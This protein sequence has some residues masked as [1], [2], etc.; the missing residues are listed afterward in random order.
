LEKKKV[1]SEEETFRRLVVE[2]RILEGT[3]EALQSRISLVNAALTELRV[4]NMTMEG[5]EKEKKE[6]HLVVPIG[7]GSYIEAT[8]RGAD[9]IIVGVGA[10]VAIE[11]TIKEAKENIGNRI[12]NLEKTGTS[13]HQQ[14]TQVIDKIGGHRAQLEEITA[15]AREEQAKSVRKT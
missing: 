9:K 10:G 15:K 1:S 13:L 4:A 6:A 8:L 7:G 12:N 3:A 5:L 14:F 11:K 2:L